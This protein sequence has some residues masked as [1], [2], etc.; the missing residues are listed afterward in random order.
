MPHGAHDNEILT[1]LA[2][3]IFKEKY[4]LGGM[5]T[6]RA[7]SS[8]GQLEKFTTISL[9]EPNVL[10]KVKKRSSVNSLM[11]RHVCCSLT[12]GTD[13]SAG[14]SAMNK[15]EKDLFS[16]SLHSSAGDAVSKRRRRENIVL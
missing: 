13:W 11:H 12:P 3:C 4:I 14:S 2:L 1:L 9:R 8:E 15:A 6:I 10:R 5:N 7:T 16:C